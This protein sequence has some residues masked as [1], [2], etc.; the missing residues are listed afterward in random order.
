[1]TGSGVA[2]G[3]AGSGVDP[4]P[5]AA[6]RAGLA[7]RVVIVTGGARGI[8]EATAERLLADGAAVALWDRDADR[9]SATASRL[10]GH[11]TIADFRYEQSDLASVEA[12]AAATVARFGRIDGL[13]NNAAIVG[14]TVPVWEYPPDAWDAVVR[15]NLTGV[16][17]CCRTIIPVMLAAGR[18]RIVNVS[19]VAGK[20]GNA[21]LG[22][23]SSVKAGVIALTKVLGKELATRGVLV[24]AITPTV[25]ETELMHAVTPEMNEAFKAKI[26]M[27]RFAQPAEVAAMIAWLLSDEVSFTT[28]SVLDL[29][30]GRTTY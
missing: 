20:E 5:T 9:L 1:M 12:A 18:G 27:G 22:C 13:V 17:Y 7:G 26:P 24:N 3:A 14:P 30:G 6:R 19:S 25:T 10:A 16:F 4:G 21:N 11:G 2:S 8:G 23:Y 15:V 28:G 29:S